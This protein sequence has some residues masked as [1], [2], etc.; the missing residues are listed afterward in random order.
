ME[1]GQL[2][3]VCPDCGDM[4]YVESYC[5]PRTDSE[6]K[7]VVWVMRVPCL[8]CMYKGGFILPLKRSE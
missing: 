2:V 1:K 3:R 5:V 8:G 7:R 6:G 4:E